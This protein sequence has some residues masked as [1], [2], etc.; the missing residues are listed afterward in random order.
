MRT[1]ANV[2][3]AV[4][5]LV[6]VRGGGA[7]ASV[8]GAK[9][10]A[11]NLKRIPPGFRTDVESEIEWLIYSEWLMLPYEQGGR[12][13]RRDAL[14]E[15]I[16]QHPY[17]NERILQELLRINEQMQHVDFRERLERYLCEYTH[18]RTAAADLCTSLLSIAAG[19]AAFKQFTPGALAI[20]NSTAALLANQIAISNFILGPTLGSLYYGLFP[21]SASFGLLAATTGGIMAALGILSTFSGI[22][23]DP[24]QQKLG[25]HDRRLHKLLDALEANLK[26]Q[27]NDYKLRDAYVA[28]VFDLLDVLNTA[29]HVLI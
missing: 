22:V 2:L 17:C 20:G 4:P 21:A 8:L 7:L 25:F 29:S 24:I 3:W 14:F 27:E 28:R 12:V 19:V 23:F 13:C 15:T 1:P 5:H 16:I 6:M 9:S 10:L 11:A 18:S 26:G